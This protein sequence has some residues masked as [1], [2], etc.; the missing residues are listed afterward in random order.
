MWNTHCCSP[1]KA[2]GFIFC[3]S[4]RISV[5]LQYKCCI[6]IKPSWTT[7]NQQRWTIR[8]I[9]A[10]STEPSSYRIPEASC[11][12]RL[13]LCQRADNL[14][15]VFFVSGWMICN[16]NF[17]ALSQLTVWTHPRASLHTVWGKKEVKRWVYQLDLELGPAPKQDYKTSAERWKFSTVLWSTLSSCR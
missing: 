14:K 5:L 9:L 3:S 13:A 16:L 6:M 11:P 8:K 12:A 2:L 4:L 7:V 15:Y 17:L 1:A 10:A